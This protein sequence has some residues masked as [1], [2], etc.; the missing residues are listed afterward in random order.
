MTGRRTDIDIQ[1]DYVVQVPY[2]IV[3]NDR[4]AGRQPIFSFTL[5]RSDF[6]AML[7]AWKAT[8]IL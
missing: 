1:K 6:H 7:L 4:A 8:P 5:V 2:V 3:E